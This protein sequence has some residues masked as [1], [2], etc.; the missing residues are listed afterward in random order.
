MAKCRR[1]VRNTKIWLTVLLSL[2]ELG[3]ALGAGH[4]AFQPVVRP[5]VP[6]ARDRLSFSRNPIDAFIGAKLSERGLAFSPEADRRALIRRLSFD[7]RGLP[8]TPEEVDAFLADG[9]ADAYERVV[10][11]FLGI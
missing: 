6:E 1:M 7:L 10:E 8:P 4:W 3:C 11:R 2:T 9:R 5:P